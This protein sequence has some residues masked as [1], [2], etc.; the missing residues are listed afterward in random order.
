MPGVRPCPTIAGTKP[1][2][3]KGTASLTQALV[4]KPAAPGTA[5]TPVGA[6]PTPAQLT[7][8]AGYIDLLFFFFLNFF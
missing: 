3:L 2:A 8:Q 5:A 6:A 1:F 7:L 4:A